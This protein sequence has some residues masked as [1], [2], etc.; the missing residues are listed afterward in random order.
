MAGRANNRTE[1]PQEGRLGGDRARI[2]LFPLAQASRA[3]GN[4]GVS[5]EPPEAELRQCASLQGQS[6]DA[7]SGA[8]LGNDLARGPRVS[9]PVFVFVSLGRETEA[10]C[11]GVGKLTAG[12]PA[13]PQITQYSP[14]RVGDISGQQTGL[15]ANTLHER[16]LSFKGKLNYITDFFKIKQKRKR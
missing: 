2:R 8:D 9:A 4:V 6:R 12:R 7:P 1:A 16:E 15:R 5:G 3:A 10:P 11:E 14:L 13:N